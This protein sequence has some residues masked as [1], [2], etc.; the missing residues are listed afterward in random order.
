VWWLIPII[1]ANREAKIRRIE[2]GGQLRK[3]VS[4]TPSQ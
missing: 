4:E 2:V 3:K 1:S